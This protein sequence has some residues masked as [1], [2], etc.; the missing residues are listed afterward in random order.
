M[1]NMSASLIKTIVL[2]FFL[3]ACEQK[4]S[5]EDV[6][7]EIRNRFNALYPAAENVRWAKEIKNYRAYFKNSGND[8]AALFDKKGNV[9]ETE[10]KIEET[11]VPDAVIKMIS[12]EYPKAQVISFSRVNSPDMV[13]YAVKMHLKKEDYKVFFSPE[14]RL[15]KQVLNTKE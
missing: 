5:N 15:I 10:M 9:K 4:I 3:C 6:P 8:I 2:I 11:E 7:E 1:Q 13:Q 14:G 12:K